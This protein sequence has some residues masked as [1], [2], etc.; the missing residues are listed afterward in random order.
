MRLSSQ[1]GRTV[2]DIFEHMTISEL[3]KWAILAAMDRH[4]NKVRAVAKELGVGKN[5]IYRKLDMYG[6]KRPRRISR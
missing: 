4:H 5:T 6:W 3:E 2:N 1:R